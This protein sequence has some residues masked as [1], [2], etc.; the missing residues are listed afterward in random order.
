MMDTKCDIRIDYPNSV[1]FV[2]LEPYSDRTFCKHWQE[3]GLHLQNVRKDLVPFVQFKKCEKHPWKSISFSTA[4]GFSLQ[5]FQKWPSSMGVFRVFWNCTNGTKSREVSHILIKMFLK[6]TL[7]FP[8]WV[9]YTVGYIE[10]FI[11]KK[12]F[13]LSA[14][15]CW[16]KYFGICSEGF[17]IRTE[18]LYEVR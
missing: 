3:K 10:V 5:L 6:T 7:V 12:C 15:P 18:C 2:S 9:C 11:P 1:R 16:L 14:I 8:I 13:V 17:W 4:A